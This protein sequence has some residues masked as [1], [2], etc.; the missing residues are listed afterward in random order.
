MAP[1]PV[2][3]LFRLGRGWS[4]L[5]SRIFNFP[6]PSMGGGKKGPVRVMDTLTGEMLESVRDARLGYDVHRIPIPVLVLKVSTSP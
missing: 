4:V 2:L 3:A 1:P 6:P 5:N